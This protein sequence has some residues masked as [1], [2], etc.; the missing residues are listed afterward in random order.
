MKR[1]KTFTKSD[2]NRNIFFQR[3][4]KR[5]REICRERKG[6]RNGKKKRRNEK[7]K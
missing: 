6:R 5:K 2:K 3:V 4:R 7:R 1:I